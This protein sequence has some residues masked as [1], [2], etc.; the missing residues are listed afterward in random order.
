[1]IAN[2]QVTSTIAQMKSIDAATSTFRDQYDAFPGDMA[3]AS[4]RLV[5]CAA[6]PCNNGNGN[7]SL[8]INVGGANGVGSEG[9]FFFN[10][11]RAAD[12][13]SGFDGTAVA[14]FGQALPTADVGGGFTVGDA[15]TGATGFTQ[16]ELRQ[17]SHYIVLTSDTGTVVAGDGVATP[18]QGARIDRK[19]DDGAPDTGSVV[20]DTANT[21]CRVNTGGVISWNEINTAVSCAVAV[22]IQGYVKRFVLY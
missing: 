4:T 5:N 12:L 10:H 8:G 15:G 9:A 7:S 1:M 11:L 16:G 22:R 18:S 21:A 13:L 17:N 3:N 2:A 19:M 20:S 14:A 6:N